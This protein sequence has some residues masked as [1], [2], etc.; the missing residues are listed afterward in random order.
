VSD[1]DFESNVGLAGGACSFYTNFAVD[2]DHCAFV[3]NSCTAS[4][5]LGGALHVYLGGSNGRLRIDDSLFAGNSAASVGAIYAQATFGG[6]A[7]IT[8]S[9][10]VGNRATTGNGGAC[11]LVADHASARNSIFWN[12]QAANGSQ[13]AVQFGALDVS[14]CDV[15]LGQPGVYVASGATLNWGAGNL[16]L[17]PQ[18]VDPDGADND[19]T[20]FGD[21][22]YRLQPSSPCLDAGDTNAI[23]LDFGDIDGDA[24]TAEPVP[25][26]LN[27]K[28]RRKDLPY[29]PDVGI[30][31]PPLVDLGC[32]E[33]QS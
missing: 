17:D 2:V 31:A 10:F 18:F 26:D 33:R 4:N 27:L 28:P 29:A 23:A 1:C 32:Y 15:M 19:P 30:G 11:M 21:N 16:D 13:L 24:N 6:I 9:T 7:E 14:S 20:T 8:S 22:V 5:G 25:F 12:N 3:A